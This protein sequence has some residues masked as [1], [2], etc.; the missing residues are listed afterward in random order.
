[1]KSTHTKSTS[2]PL[3]PFSFISLSSICVLEF[4]RFKR[5]QR[6]MC[7]AQGSIP[8]REIALAALHLE[9]LIRLEQ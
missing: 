6:A 8:V 4:E 1:V 7:S 3:S 5:G 9:I 2:S